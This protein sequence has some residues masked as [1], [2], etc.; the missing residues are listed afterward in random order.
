MVLDNP[1]DREA[2]LAKLTPAERAE[3]LAAE[4]AARRAEERAEQRELERILAQKHAER[5]REQNNNHTSTADKSSILMGNETL[6]QQQQRIVFI[7]KRKREQLQNQEP[8]HKNTKKKPE[9]AVIKPAAA[10]TSTINSTAEETSLLSEKERKIIQESYL[11]KTALEMENEDG[12]RKKKQYTKKMTFKFRWENTDDTFPEDDPLYA[13]MLPRSVIEATNN[14]KKSKD[15]DS[16]DSRQSQLNVWNKP[17]AQMTPRDWRIF[18]ENYEIS[19]KGGRAPPP[20][21]SFRESPS[22]ELPPLHPA[23]L[24][25]IENVLRFKEPSPIQRQAIPVGLQRRDMIGIAETGSG[26]VHKLA[27]FGH[28]SA[29]CIVLSH[30]IFL[31][32]N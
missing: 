13:S 24:D 17:I 10:A 21:R 22:P 8:S 2:F 27:V 25:A 19:V 11:G 12:A 29:P 20:M 23:L 14:R 16:N 4:A 1:D 26:K 31:I 15:P 9:E 32:F 18:R 3:A 5:R 30:K 6:P 7:P 28:A